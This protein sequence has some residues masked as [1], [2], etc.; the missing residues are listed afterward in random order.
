MT[1]GRYKYKGAYA[2]D[3]DTDERRVQPVLGGQGRDLASNELAAVSNAVK[4]INT[5]A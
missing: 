5:W 4:A 3:G 2:V 1:T